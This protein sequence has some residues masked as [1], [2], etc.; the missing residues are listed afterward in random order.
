MTGP[1]PQA[2][3][4]TTGADQLVRDLL[5]QGS[6]SAVDYKAPMSLPTKRQD[7]AKLANT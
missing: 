4:P 5:A 6:E 1:P 7:R 3:H 2:P